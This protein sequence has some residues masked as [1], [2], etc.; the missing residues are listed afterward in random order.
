MDL[1]D[2]KD[3]LMN[4]NGKWM[5]DLKD[6]PM[7]Y[8]A[9]PFWSWNTK[10]D[11]EESL[12]QSSELYRQGAGGYFM[13][14][15]GGLSTDYMG[16][17]W[18]DNVRA[19]VQDS[20]KHGGFAYGYDE[21]GWPSG[22]GSGEVNGLGLDYQQKYLR[23]EHTGSPK[24]GPD[25]IAN[26]PAPQGGCYHFFYEVNPF[27]VDTLNPK[28]TEAFLT[29]THEKYLLQLG[30][31]FPK[32][33]GF[34]TDEPQV[35]RNGIPWSF[36]LD[37]EYRAAY[38]QE[39]IPLLPDLFYDS[40]TSARTRYQFWKLVERLFTTH[41]TKQVYDWCLSHGTRLTGH[42]VLEDTLYS[43]LTSNGACMPGY[44]YMTIPGVDWLGRSVSRNLIFS[45]VCSAAAQTG[46]KQILTESFALCGWN[47]SFE[48]L[49]WILEWQMVKG[50]NLLCPHL[51]PYSLAGI[52][53]RDYPSGH[54]YQNPWWNDY[55]LF[56]DFAARV[57]MLLAKGA[58][59]CRLLVLH[60]ESSAWVSYD[61]G[62]NRNTPI[63]HFDSQLIAYLAA[64][65]QSQIEYHLGDEWMIE[66]LGRVDGKQLRV[67][68]M[69]Y[70]AVLV[71]PSVTWDECTV[72][73]LERFQA[74]G[75]TLVFSDELPTL[76]SG[77]PD[78]DERLTKLAQACPKVSAQSL[79]SLLGDSFRTARVQD[80][81]GNNVDIQVTKRSFDGAVMY[82]F[83]NSYAREIDATISV[84]GKSAA[85]LDVLTG[86][87]VP[88]SFIEQN[89][90][91]TLSHTFA[92]KG[93]L[94][95]FTSDRSDRFASAQTKPVRD[96]VNRSLHSDWRIVQCDENAVTLD[97]CDVYFDG[98][99]IE[100]QCPVNDIQEMACAL[101]R[102]V[103]IAMVFS[104]EVQDLPDGPYF[105]VV[106]TPE[107]QTISINGTPVVQ[108]YCGYYW[109]KAFCRLDISGM[110]SIGKNSIRL[111]TNFQQSEQK[112]RYLK[113]CVSFESNKNKLTYD[114]E[115]EA[116][117]LVGRFGVHSAAP[118][119]PTD[120]RALVTDG[121]FSLTKPRETVSAGDLTTQGFPFFAGS[122]T[123]ANTF[124][125]QE[126]QLAGRCLR[127]SKRGATVTKVTVNG[128]ALPPIVWSP[129][130]VDLTGVLVAGENTIFVELIGD[131][132]NLLGPHHLE[133]E[134][135]SVGPSCFFRRS[136]IWGASPERWHTSYTFVE[137]GLFLD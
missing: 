88:V 52:R 112:Y 37:A 41:Y 125:L 21:N 32:M 115:I 83:V 131:L 44:E 97:V 19:C 49:K 110:L 120:N 43:Q 114:D 63:H 108:K 93:S 51:S 113:D 57:G 137:Y 107:K 22:F 80:R 70:D 100:T 9:L 123:L 48:E 55:H 119:R 34:F 40:C 126:D 77:G 87:I 24:N 74:A 29:S 17:E 101:S 13:H 73:M 25:T 58:I 10:L 72:A 20:E 132:R 130:E 30:N 33:A 84:A 129:Y 68:E 78:A 122:I 96:P 59:E 62:H 39:L 8:R 71:P 56:L 104:V 86:D 81:D 117:Y 92:E 47:V 53:K 14:A 75:G 50:V 69:S 67:G 5:D 95:F 18:M 4:T 79:P 105:L 102:P 136:A 98:E 116:I 109:D 76:I 103:R 134:R 111:E 85:A 106:E 135:Y 38:G 124:S 121:G 127:F 12:W 61:D 35:S 91:V 118:Y 11:V 26:V 65:E 64:L 46:K 31:D 3:F 133:E 89:G 42:L 99:L 2:G 36:T 54:F 82:Y 128:H 23:V 27:Y 60:P 6:P 7:Q 1:R 28:A 45:Q 94:L 90:Q 66:R 15:R 16:K